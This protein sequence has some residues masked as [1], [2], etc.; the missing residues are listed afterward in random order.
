MRQRQK[1]RVDEKRGNK[2]E[3]GERKKWKRDWEGETVKK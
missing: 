1:E 2:K 3:R